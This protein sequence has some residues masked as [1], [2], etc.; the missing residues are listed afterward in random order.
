MMKNT[1]NIFK[2]AAAVFAVALGLSSCLEKIPGDYILE[3]DTMN[4][5]AEA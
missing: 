4:T 5:V 1:F 3:E 2:K